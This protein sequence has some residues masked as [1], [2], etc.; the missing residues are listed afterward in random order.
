[1]MR[2]LGRHFALAF[3]ALSS[4]T[5]RLVAQSPYH[6]GPNVEVTHVG[7]GRIV[8]E[9]YV[10][11]DPRHSRRL[12]AAAI[13]E[14]ADTASNWFFVSADGGSSWTRSLA[15]ARSVDP[16]C[17]ISRDGVAFAASVHDSMPSGD[18]YLQ[19]QRSLD[20]GRTWMEST[21]HDNARN[22]DRAYVTAGSGGRVFVHAYAPAAAP[23]GTGKHADALVYASR[24][25]GR[26]F[27]RVATLPGDSFANSWFFPANGAF[28]RMGTF[29]GLLVEL[30]DA[31]NNMFRG[32]SDSTSAPRAPNGELR[33][34]HWRPGEAVGTR[35][36]TD[37]YYDRRVP[38]LSM[39]SL[40][41]DRGSGPCAG[42]LYAVWPDARY[43]RRTQ[44]LLVQ[45]DDEGRTWTKPRVV[46]DG[47]DSAAFGPNDFMP[48]VAVNTDG[49][50]GVSWY[51]RRDN[52]DSLSYWPRFRASLDCGASWLT[53]TRVSIAPNHL[54]PDDRHLNGGDTSG[55]SADAA[56]RFHVLWI[57]NRTAV[58]EAWTSTVQVRGRVRAPHR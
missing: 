46:S 24:D 22:L 44:I 1:M 41:V 23:R 30:D 36:I 19:V 5:Y 7:N 16:S 4:A 15:V 53:S 25:S 6:L 11:A 12:L 57:D 31:Q 56:G 26:T 51:D 28:T 21:I 39:A 54:K 18:S 42:T 27:D 45:S 13:V 35:A 2:H 55:L 49:I 17:A 48:M 3:I 33:L 10:C 50:V 29:V 47:P 34:I 8:Q 32:R 9:T 38:Q 52:D 14:H 58:A 40:A 20:G 43:G 37:V